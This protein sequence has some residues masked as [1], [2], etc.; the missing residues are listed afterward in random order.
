MDVTKICPDCVSRGSAELVV[1]VHT[2]TSHCC[3]YSSCCW[4]FSLPVALQVTEVTTNTKLLLQ[5][6]VTVKNN[7]NPYHHSAELKCIPITST[8]V[9]FPQLP[10]LCSQKPADSTQTVGDHRQ[11]ISLTH[12]TDRPLNVNKQKIIVVQFLK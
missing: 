7:E 6:A 4:S 9:E 11:C 12:R 2:T 10:F 3:L 5:Y 1:A 8:L